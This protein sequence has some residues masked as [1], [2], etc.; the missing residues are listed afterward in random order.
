GWP[1][2]RG[3]RGRAGSSSMT[4]LVLGAVAGASIIWTADNDGAEDPD[5]AT[6]P[7][8]RVEC[9]DLRTTEIYAIPM[10][11]EFGNFRARTFSE[12]DTA[13][14]NLALVAHAR[15]AEQQL[16]ADIEAASLDLTDEGTT[17]SAYRD[18]LA[19]LVRAA[20]TYRARVRDDD[21]MFRVIAPSQAPA[22]FAIDFIR[23]MAGGNGYAEV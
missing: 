4:P 21:L 16:L 23:G 2:V 5:P 20:A 6:K 10:C 7:C 15:V 13:A 8:I 22:I 19:M 1:A 12:W 14:T 9:G 17:V 3:G 11:L 18:W